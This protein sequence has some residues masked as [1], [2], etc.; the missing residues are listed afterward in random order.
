MISDKA[1]RLLNTL[2]NNQYWMGAEERSA[3]GVGYSSEVKYNKMLAEYD[4]TRTTLIKYIEELEE[5]SAELQRHLPS[6]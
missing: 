3:E 6:I 1:M 2:L 5:D 4:L